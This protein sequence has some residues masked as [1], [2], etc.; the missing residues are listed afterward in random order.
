MRSIG[1]TRS[2]APTLII[3]FGIPDDSNDFRN[4]A[5]RGSSFINER[6]SK[7]RVYESYHP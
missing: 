5:G 2:I 7:D 6:L 1:A 4:I 3:S